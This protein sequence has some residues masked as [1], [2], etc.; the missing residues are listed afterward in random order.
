[1]SEVE[2]KVEYHLVDDDNHGGFH[3]RAGLVNDYVIDYQVRNLILCDDGKGDPLKFEHEEE[4]GAI[5]ATTNIE[6]GAIYL[7][8]SIKW[9]GCGH[10]NFSD[11]GYI[12]SCSRQEMV[13]L[14]KLFDKLYDI[15]LELMPD[16][17]DYLS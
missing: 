6:K 5:N 7:D 1:M 13:R 14:G 10:H 15:A 12:H 16:N 17:G 4:N 11:N 9:D 3:I 8:G 2:W